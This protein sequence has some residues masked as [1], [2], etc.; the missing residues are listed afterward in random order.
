[1]N[2]QGHL[3]AYDFYR[4]IELQ[5]DNRGLDSFPVSKFVV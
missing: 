4:A 5:T 2:L 1:M 3:T